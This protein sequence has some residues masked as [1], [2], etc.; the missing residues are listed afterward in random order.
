MFWSKSDD[1]LVHDGSEAGSSLM[2]FRDLLKLKCRNLRLELNL[3]LNVE[4]LSELNF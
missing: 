1:F 4:N 3:Q 2:T